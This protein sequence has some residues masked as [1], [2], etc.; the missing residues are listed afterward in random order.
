MLITFTLYNQ[1]GL[2]IYHFDS[3]DNESL[4]DDSAATPAREARTD[5]DES[6]DEFWDDITESVISR[7]IQSGAPPLPEPATKE[8]RFHQTRSLVYWILY[9]LLIWQS[10][11]HVSDNGL[12][13][14]LQFIFQLFKAMNIYIPDEILTELI[15]VFPTSLYMLRQFLAMDRDD[16]TKFVVCPHC[17]KCYNYY[18]CLN[19]VNGQVVGKRCTNTLFVR[20]RG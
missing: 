20:G 9:F 4:H 10:M 2:G 19:E 13:Y 6:D 16:F 5:T 17:C 14:L 18:E 11:C 3:S 7:D 8:R 12:T 15:M 1:Q